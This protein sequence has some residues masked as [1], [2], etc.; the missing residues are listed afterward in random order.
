MVWE[1]I[2]LARGGWESISTI[3]LTYLT[4]ET[5]T[6]VK[7]TPNFSQ[8]AI[9]Q[10]NNVQKV[11]RKSWCTACSSGYLIRCSY[12][13]ATRCGYLQRV[14]KTP[15]DPLAGSFP[16]RNCTAN[17]VRQVKCEGWVIAHH[18]LSDERLCLPWLADMDLANSLLAQRR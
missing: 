18:V 8:V 3:W 10:P 4:G 14:Q 2:Q 11:F 9:S 17:A 13:P 7:T 6:L 12:V 15:S 1:V 5:L 16:Q